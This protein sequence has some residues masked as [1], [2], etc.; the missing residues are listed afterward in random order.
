MAEL[1]NHQ[2][3]KDTVDDLAEI[4]RQEVALASRKT[5]LKMQ[6][7]SSHSQHNEKDNVKGGVLV[8]QWLTYA[9]SGWAI[10]AIAALLVNVLWY[11]IV[12]K[13]QGA[14]QFS[15][16]GIAT[17]LVLL[18]ISFV[19]NLFY[20]KHDYHEKTGASNAIMLI[21]AVIFALCG[22]AALIV[23]VFSVVMLIT[24]NQAGSE[25]LVSIIA[26]LVMALIYLLTFIRTI[27]PVRLS[28]VTKALPIIMGIISIALLVMASVGPASRLVSSKDDQLITENLPEIN[29]SVQKYAKEN[30][31][32][33][34]SL[35]QLRMDESSSSADKLTK[36]GLVDYK[37]NVKKV[38]I[39][40]RQDSSSI[41]ALKNKSLEIEKPSSVGRTETHYYELCV[42]YKFRSGNQEAYSY[43][44]DYD[45]VD[46]YGT[47]L[48]V[49]SHPEGN[50]CYKQRVQVEYSSDD[51]R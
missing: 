38:N 36:S 40:Y 12:D 1:N 9:F 29:S 28:V 30:S 15:P 26:G 6:A 21:H 46:G 48:N 51:T 47:Y 23:S 27:N 13:S 24:S 25:L 42:N 11:F 5:Q 35:S 2:Q 8:L 19:C 18:P 3:N 22:I 39:E 31:K 7:V 20:K 44:D 16:Y 17:V 14:I 4:E 49:Y 10:L 33:P 37:P 50:T 45:S 34:A 43:T 32:L 41:N